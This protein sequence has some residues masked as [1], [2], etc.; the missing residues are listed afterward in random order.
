MRTSTAPQASAFTAKG[1]PAPRQLDVKGK[2][3]GSGGGSGGSS[4]EDDDGADDDASTSS[5]VEVRRAFIPEVEYDGEFG[6]SLIRAM[7]GRSTGRRLKRDLFKQGLAQVCVSIGLMIM[8]DQAARDFTVT[9]FLELSVYGKSLISLWWLVSIIG[10]LLCFVTLFVVYG[11]PSLVTNRQL[12]STILKIY[13]LIQ[14]VNWIFTFSTLVTTIRTVNE[15]RRYDM[16]LTQKTLQPYFI[17]AVFLLLSYTCC[18]CGNTMNLS[19][20]NDELEFGGTILEPELDAPDSV[21]DLSGMTLQQ[22]FHALVAYP[23]A[24]AYQTLDLLMAIYALLLRM[25][26]R[27]Q[28]YLDDRALKHQQ[29]LAREAADARAG[30][31]R[32]KGLAAR[33]LKTV[34]RCFTRLG[35]LLVAICLGKWGQLLR[36]GDGKG[37]ADDLEQQQQRQQQQKAQAEQVLLNSAALSQEEQER[38]EREREALEA[39]R[40]YQREREERVRREAQQIAEEDR[41]RRRKERE[42]EEER[43][44]KEA[45]EAAESPFLSVPEFKTQWGALGVAGQFQCK[46]AHAPQLLPFTSHMRTQGFHVVFASTP[47]PEDIEVGVCNIKQAPGETRF[48]ARFLSSGMSFSAVMKCESAEAVPAFVKKFALAKILKI[49]TT[50]R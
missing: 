34:T 8:T 1:N 48:M 44:R 49:D 19:Y 41:E 22:L 29:E 26:R 9:H 18:I 21:W 17:A 4:D 20:L 5:A 47:T 36:R 45:L 38:M 35:L 32:R 31:K 37:A 33:L 12:T 14:V 6:Y 11:W 16:T 46:L 30:K 42:A 27:L 15:N 24:W 40:K 43:Q 25:W 50:K 13:M 10:F 7:R 39:E 23:I 2:V 3:L 28:R